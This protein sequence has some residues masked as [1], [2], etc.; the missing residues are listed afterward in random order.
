MLV[1]L[2]SWYDDDHQFT[3]FRDIIYQSIMKM[4]M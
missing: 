3:A 1:I 2:K 4:F